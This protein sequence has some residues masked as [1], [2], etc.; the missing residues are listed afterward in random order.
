MDLKELYELFLQSEGVCIDTRS[1]REGE[2]FFALKGEKQDG[3]SYAKE[4]LEKGAKAAII[5]DPSLSMNGCIP[6]KDSL[7][8]LQ[9]LAAHHRQ[10]L[11]IPIIAITGS[12]G[13][14]TSKELIARVLDKEYS[15]FA[16]QGNLNNHI[17]LPLSLLSIDEQHEMVVLEFGANHPGE[18]RLLAEISDPT[19]GIVTNI[20]LDHLEGF[21]DK[22][23]VYHG[24][25]ELIDFL[26]RKGGYAF[27]NID[28][29]WIR[30]MMEGHSHY[31]TYGKSREADLQGKLLDAAP[32]LKL[33]WWK[34]GDAKT[35]S[36]NTQ[37]VGSYNF[38]NILS[39]LC[40]GAH[41]KVE[42]EDMEEAIAS[43][44]PENKRSQ[45]VHTD[46]NTVILDAYNANPSSME[47]SLESFAAM[48]AEA[49]GFILGDM[50][51]LGD[52][53]REA[54]E[55]ILQLLEKEGLENGLL[56]GRAFQACTSNEGIPR[57]KDAKEAREF[58]EKNPMEGMTILVKASRGLRLETLMDLL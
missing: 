1:L 37:L 48:E 51:E 27:F 31:K 16:T 33:E 49:K 4:A 2:L 24:N 52:H 29:E 32:Y 55:R 19:H 12:N 57:V 47:A 53:E 40:I 15:C 9:E 21:G 35:S 30:P 6:V 5:D 54:H 42:D 41:F 26:A 25:K 39:A 20:G 7:E 43:Y 46:K 14:T 56:V 58:L 38:P 28:D 45:V 36:F 50:L 11:D 34:K 44:R 8:T 22:K 10:H 3:N 23:G 13:K 18:N 17:G